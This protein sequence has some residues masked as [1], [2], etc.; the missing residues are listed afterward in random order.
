MTNFFE[1]LGQPFSYN[2][3]LADLE[4]AF[5]E[6]QKKTHPDNFINQQNTDLSYQQQQSALVN[7]AYMTLVD[8]FKRGVYYLSLHN[9][10]LEE[11][12]KN[13][14]AVFLMEQMEIREALENA[15]TLEMKKQIY[16]SLSEK[17]NKYY[18]ELSIVLQNNT[19]EHLQKAVTLLTE[20]RFWKNILLYKQ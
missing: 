13:L 2:V 14:S 10:Q 18:N 17:I 20:L 7:Q 19:P 5:I 9:I 1:L 4:K 15:N 12:T 8:P 16:G 11:N 6:A 3:S